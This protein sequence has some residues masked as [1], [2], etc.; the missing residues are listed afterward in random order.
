MSRVV[1]GKRLDGSMGLDVALPN[2]DALTEDRND[3]TRFSYSSDWTDIVK[4]AAFGKVSI[5]AVVPGT[6]NYATIHEVVAIPNYGYI[7]HFEMRLWDGASR[8]YDDF[9][10]FS[11]GYGIRA[12]VFPSVMS[13]IKYSNPYK[14]IYLIYRYPTDQQ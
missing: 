1:L 11:D 10:N 2:H 5:P 4:Y 12:D 7:P 13:F 3:A 9:A 8:V 6:N 14:L